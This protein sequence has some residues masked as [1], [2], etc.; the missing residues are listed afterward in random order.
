MIAERFPRLRIEGTIEER[1]MNF[2]GDVVIAAGEIDYIDRSE[3]IHAA[4]EE[5]MRNATHGAV[6]VPEDEIPF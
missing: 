1:M 5:W 6:E 4:H 2:G 3:E